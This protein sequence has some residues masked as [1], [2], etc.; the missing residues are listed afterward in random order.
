MYHPTK[1]NTYSFPSTAFSPLSLL[2]E[3]RHFDVCIDCNFMKSQIFPTSSFFTLTNKT[4]NLI[5]PSEGILPFLLIKSDEWRS[6]K[7]S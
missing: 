4:K 1:Q 7:A 3:I 5:Y 6:R 2:A